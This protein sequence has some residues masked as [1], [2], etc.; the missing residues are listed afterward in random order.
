MTRLFSYVV[1]HDEGRSPNPFGRYCSLAHCKFSRNGTRK[2][3][4]ESA[5]Q[6]DWIVG[7]GGASARSAGHGRV[8]YAMKI[9]YKL[10]LAE[11]YRDTRFKG[12]ID[13]RPEDSHREDRFVLIGTEFYYFGANAPRIPPMF[14]RHP[15]EKKGPGFRKDFDEAFADSF[16]AW[17]QASFR[18]GRQGN[19]VCGMPTEQRVNHPCC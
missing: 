11:Y 9:K 1:E 7:T 15:L 14:K 3:I 5:G 12:R 18:R 2:N 13:N 6:G 8:I 4:I 19:P 16:A 17:L 10:T